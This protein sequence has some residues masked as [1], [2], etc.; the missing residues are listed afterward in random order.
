[1][2]IGPL[3][4]FDAISQDALNGRLREWSHAMGE[5]HRPPEYGFW[6]HGLAHDGRL[7][8][9]V[10]ANT[11]IRETCAGLDRLEAV[12][13]SRVCAERRDLCRILVRLWREFVFPCLR[14]PRRS[15]PFPWAVSY[16]DAAMHRGD[17]YR[18]DGWV[19]LQYAR[20]G[21]VDPRTGRRG[22]NRI[23]WGWHAEPDERQRRRIEY[24]IAGLPVEDAA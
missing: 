5:L 15:R 24:P 21:S 6:A 20:S 7:V 3:V 8:G 14:P 2:I 17:L 4:T 22:R 16:Q 9:V 11:L 23:I 12:E 1:M 19:P 18:F 13:L 10:S